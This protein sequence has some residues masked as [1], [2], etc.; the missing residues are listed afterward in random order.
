[1]SVYCYM[2]LMQILLVVSMQSSLKSNYTVTSSCLIVQAH[3]KSLSA[4]YAFTYHLRN[5]SVYPAFK[6]TF[7]SLYCGSHK[8]NIHF[9]P[10]TFAIYGCYITNSRHFNFMQFSKNCWFS[11]HQE[12]RM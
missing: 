2:F 9:S 10:V 5:G 1:M 8:R 4:P 11:N 3:F 12:H 7:Q 6:K